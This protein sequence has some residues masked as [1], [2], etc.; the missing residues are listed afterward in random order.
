MDYRTSLTIQS[1]SCDRTCEIYMGFR[2]LLT[3]SESLSKLNTGTAFPPGFRKI[4]HLPHISHQVAA[5]IVDA[6]TTS[7][8]KKF[9]GFRMT[10]DAELRFS[11]ARCNSI[12]QH[13]NQISSQQLIVSESSNRALHFSKNAS[14][15]DFWRI[16]C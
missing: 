5:F 14:V 10:T 16:I 1:F 4:A 12:S 13:I 8:I 9:C 6:N 11:D 7:L 2:P 3:S 15:T